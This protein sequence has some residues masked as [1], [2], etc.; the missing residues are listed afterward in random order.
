M[1][2]Q[3]IIP[4]SY[5]FTRYLGIIETYKERRYKRMLWIT[6]PLLRSRQIDPIM[7]SVSSGIA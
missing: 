4:S 5:S 6:D 3:V 7:S 1:M 2:I